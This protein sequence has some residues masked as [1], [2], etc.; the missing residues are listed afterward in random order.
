MAGQS[1]A[2][3]QWQNSRMIARL[4]ERRRRTRMLA[5]SFQSTIPQ[6][7]GVSMLLLS[8]SR[9]LMFQELLDIWE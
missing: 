9:G 5:R 3:S 7:I 8:S 4:L 6:E 2:V 1:G